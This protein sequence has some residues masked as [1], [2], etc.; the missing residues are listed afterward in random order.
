MKT[1]VRRY[2]TITLGLLKKEE[3]E[4]KEECQIAIFYFVRCV[5]K[6][7]YYSDVIYSFD[8]KSAIEHDGVV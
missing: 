1:S 7:R 4:N 2:D 5:R 6:L 8:W 3:E